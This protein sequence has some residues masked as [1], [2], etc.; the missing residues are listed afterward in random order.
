MLADFAPVPYQSLPY[1]SKV[2]ASAYARA[3]ANEFVRLQN[4]GHINTEP[5][6]GD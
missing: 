6:H 5:S 1:P 4:L 2:V 3:W